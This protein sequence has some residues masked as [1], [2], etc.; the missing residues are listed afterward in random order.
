MFFTERSFISLGLNIIGP[1]CGVFSMTFPDGGVAAGVKKSTGAVESLI[2]VGM[3]S[4][5]D[6]VAIG[7]SGDVMGVDDAGPVLGLPPPGFITST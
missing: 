7:T 6:E 5:G 2:G 1:A 4:C 3:N